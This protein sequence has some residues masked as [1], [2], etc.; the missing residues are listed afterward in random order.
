MGLIA[1]AKRR[2]DRRDVRF[3]SKADM[4]ASPHDVR[5][6]Q[7]A[8]IRDG[9]RHVRYVPKS[10]LMQRSNRA[11]TIAGTDEFLPAVGVD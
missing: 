8:D 3:G 11:T 4:D 5:F 2:I 9:N 7:K 6:I 10:G 1:R